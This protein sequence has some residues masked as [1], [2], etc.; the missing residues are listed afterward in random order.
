MPIYDVYV[1][2]DQCSQPHSVHVKLS[3]D[4]TNLDK[5]GLADYYADNPFPSEIVFMQTN[6]YRCPHTKQ[7]FSAE[8]IE[9]AVFFTAK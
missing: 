8:D 5:T 2:C 1:V 6:K 4:E 9:K 3:L 7:F